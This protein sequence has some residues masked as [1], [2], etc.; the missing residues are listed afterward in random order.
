MNCGNNM[1]NKTCN[2]CMHC[3]KEYGYNWGEGYPQE[4]QESCKKGHTWEFMD[5]VGYEHSCDDL[6]EGIP[7]TNLS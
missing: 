5:D 3:H 2:E 4:I 7:S 1:N 6:E